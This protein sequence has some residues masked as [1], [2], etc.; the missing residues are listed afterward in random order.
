MGS[1]KAQTSSHYCGTSYSKHNLGGRNTNFSL[2]IMLNLWDAYSPQSYKH[3]SISYSHIH[4]RVL[5]P[6]ILCDILFACDYIIHIMYVRMRE[7]VMVNV[8]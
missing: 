4:C 1:K 7:M 6:S 5:F 8:Y 3:Y 2:L